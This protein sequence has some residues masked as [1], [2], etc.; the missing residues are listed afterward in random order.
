[1]N[2]LK[3]FE[4]PKFGKI[5]TITEDGKTLFCGVDA[6]NAL[7]YKNSRDALARHCKGVVKRDIPT[8]SGV[9]SLNF[10]TEGDLCRLAAKSELPGANEFESWIFDEV[11][12]AILRTG[13][14]SIAPV[15]T[16]RPPGSLSWRSGKADQRDPAR[17]VGY[18]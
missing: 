5:R 17:D 7:G 9:Q 12:P 8:S 11:I 1:M 3:I 14:Y 6:T 16:T 15:K 10:I 18:G 4:H 2:E 13:T